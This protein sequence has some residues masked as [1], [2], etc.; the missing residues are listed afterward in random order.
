MKHTA[1]FVLVV[2]VL[3]VVVITMMMMMMIMIIIII[4][5]IIIQDKEPSQ[6]LQVFWND[7]FSPFAKKKA[8][9]KLV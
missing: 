6:S 5:I 1:T 3:V 2:S 4:I 7:F 9:G 8:A